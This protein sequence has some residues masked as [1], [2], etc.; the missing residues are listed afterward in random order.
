MTLTNL[1]FL[2]CNLDKPEPNKL[3]TIKYTKFVPFV[4]NFL[5]NIQESH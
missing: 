4:V 3:Q 5:L 2:I 1:Q